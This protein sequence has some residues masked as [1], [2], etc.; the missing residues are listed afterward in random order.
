MTQETHCITNALDKCLFLKSQPSFSRILSEETNV[1]KIFE[2]SPFSFFGSDRSSRSHNLR[3]FGPNLSRAFKFHLRAVWVSL[4]P[5]SGQSQVSLRSVSGQSC[6]ISQCITVA[7][8]I[9]LSGQLPGRWN[10][11]DHTFE[12]RLCQAG[13]SSE[14]MLTETL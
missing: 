1:G 4:R 2:N 11:R 3:S 8:W 14:R 10:Q 5:V 9:K 7:E 6:Y 13:G 12:T